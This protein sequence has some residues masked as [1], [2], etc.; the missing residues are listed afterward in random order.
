MEQEPDPIEHGPEATRLINRLY[1]QEDGRKVKNFH[2]DVNKK[3]FAETHGGIYHYDE[4]TMHEW[5]DWTDA[6]T[7][8]EERAEALA[9]EIS[10]FMDAAEDPRRSRRVSSS[11]DYWGR[12]ID[13][14]HPDYMTVD[15]M[16]EHVNT[17]RDMVGRPA[18][19][20]AYEYQMVLEGHMEP[21]Q[22]LTVDDY[23]DRWKEILDKRCPDDENRYS[24]GLTRTD[25]RDEEDGYA[26]FG[27][28]EDYDVTRVPGWKYGWTRAE[29]E[30]G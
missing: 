16:V 17:C 29:V 7:T 23:E 14:I 24:N 21:A 12:M 6:P 30:N 13:P 10:D 11:R 19:L 4:A 5:I 1:N 27:L 2:F 9:K 8:K 26:A 15:K 3:A 18:F 25:P 22:G 20:S 28:G